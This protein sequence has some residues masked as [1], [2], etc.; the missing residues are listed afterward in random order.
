MLAIML[1]AESGS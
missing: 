1:F